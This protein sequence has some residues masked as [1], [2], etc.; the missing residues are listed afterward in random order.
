MF[1]LQ[2]FF[3]TSGQTLAYSIF[4]GLLVISIHGWALAFMSRTL[5]DRGP[6]HDGRLTF[7]PLVHFDLVG[8]FCVCLAQIGWIKPIQIDVT[9]LRF[10]RASIWMVT[11]GSLLILVFSANL[12]W[13]LRPMLVRHFPGGMPAVV[14]VGVLEA[15]GKISISYA[16]FN[17]IPLP[18]FSMGHWIAAFRSIP[19]YRLKHYW[20]WLTMAL[21]LIIA[22]GLPRLA[23]PFVHY[24][25]NI[26][27]FNW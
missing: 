15:F 26:L 22:T 21:G 18:P 23:N 14:A 17:L 4:A 20:L 25:Q 7:N 27:L 3:A 16:L 8:T 24:L 10:G 6:Q 9:Q 13:Q 1:D 2:R 11:A 12:A 5:G 19:S